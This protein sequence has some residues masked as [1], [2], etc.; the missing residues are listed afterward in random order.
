MECREAIPNLVECARARVA[1]GGNVQEHLAKCERCA[2]RWDAECEL[3]SHLRQM[4][5]MAAPRRSGAASRA[6]L[7]RQFSARHWRLVHPAWGIGLAAAAGLLIVMATLRAPLPTSTPRHASP[8]MGAWLASNSW[9]YE[10][11]SE[12]YSAQDE[13]FTAVPYV[14]PPDPGERLSVMHA[15]LYPA[16]LTTLGVSIDP[17]MMTSN[18]NGTIHAD[19][20]VGEDGLPRA[21]RLERGDQRDGSDF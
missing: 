20:V 19:V 6:D 15:E 12:T 10:P 14:P 3:A 2:E 4:R 21:I 13:G 5:L 7:M 11:S 8:A 17:A 16:A 1:P 18:G 9:T